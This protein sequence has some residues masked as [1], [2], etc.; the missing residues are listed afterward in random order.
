MPPGTG[1]ATSPVTRRADLD[2]IQELLPTDVRFFDVLLGTLS[3]C[4]EIHPDA[5]GLPASEASR[6]EMA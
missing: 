6:D 5:F 1:P 4:L 2:A 3:R